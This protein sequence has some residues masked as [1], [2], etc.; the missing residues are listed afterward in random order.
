MRDSTFIPLKPKQRKFVELMVYQGLT[1]D[2]AFS[3]IMNEP[4]TDETKAAIGRRASQCF[5][6]PQV[7][8]YYDALMKPIREKKVNKAAWTKEL[9][10]EK[11][12]R[13]IGHAEDELYGADGEGKGRVTMSRLQAI[14]LPVKEL[15]TINGYNITSNVNLS[16]EIVQIVGED[17]LED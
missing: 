8:T 16:G 13:L 3:Q 7:R 17:S 2:E 6:L 14:L 4:I 15:N 5:N 11:L 10:E 9:A 12:M 1:K